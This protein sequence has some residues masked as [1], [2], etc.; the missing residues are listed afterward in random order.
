MK[1]GNIY[2]GFIAAIAG[3]LSK[4]KWWGSKTYSDPHLR[5]PYH[6]PRSRSG[7]K[8]NRV[9]K[10]RFPVPDCVPGTVTYRDWLVRHL[11]YDRRLADGYIY[12]Y[13]NGYTIKMPMPADVLT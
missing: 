5:D 1:G 10:K 7:T 11:G 6:R 8:I 9:G 4:F 12:A 2:R 13:L 3:L